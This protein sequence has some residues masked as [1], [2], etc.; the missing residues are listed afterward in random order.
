[1]TANVDGVP[2]KFATLGLTYDDVLLLPG[3]SDMCCPT[4]VDTSSLHLAERAGEHPAAVRRHGQGHRGPHGHRHGPP[5]RRRRAAPQPVHRGPGQPGRPGQA[6]RVRHGHRPDHGAPGRHARRGRRAVREVPHQRRPGHRRARASC[7]ASSPTATWPSRSDRSPPGARGHD[8]DA[9][10]HRQGRH[11]RRGRHGAAAPPQD[12]EAAAGR[13]RRASSRASSRSRTSS[14]PRSTRTPPR[15]PRA[16]CSSARPSASAGDAFERAQALVEA[17]VDFIVVDTA[18][19]HSRSVARHGSPRSSRTSGVDVIGG[20]VA[21][22][23]GAQA[24]I[25][26]GV[27]GIKVGVGPGSICTTRVVAGIGVPQVTAIYEAALAAKAAGVPVIGD[28]GLQYSGDI[29]K[30]LVAGADTVMLG[31]LL[32]G[33][34]ESPGRAAVH[35]RQAVQVVPRHGLAGRDAVPRP[36]PL[37]L[38][39]PLLPGGASPPTTSSSPRASRARCPT[40]AR[41]PRSSTSSSAACAS[42]CATSAAAPSPSCRT[43][44][45]VRPDHLGG[46]QGEPPARHPD[47]GRGAELQP[48]SRQRSPSARGRR[49]GPGRSGAALAV[50]VGDT[51]RRRTQRERPHT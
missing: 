39:G 16:G 17:G 26:A 25:D 21:T 10:G 48:A 29:A 12:R 24:L 35:Q 7:S 40:A 37:V 2:E 34:E 1:M 41:C 31:S 3:A 9:A 51:G 50:R 18:H 13:R 44:R 8:A 5:G 38:Q 36:G 14:R 4:Q 11:L 42:R 30:A 43:K 46:P 49:G 27:D 47:D 19:G 28:G 33:C 20:N 15:T 32:A 23:D 6:L 22:R 45:P